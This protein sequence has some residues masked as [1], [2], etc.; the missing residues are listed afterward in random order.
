MR[1]N[2]TRMRKE[3]VVSGEP[4]QPPARRDAGQQTVGW[5]LARQEV[6]A[7]ATLEA[8]CQH[9]TAIKRDLTASVRQSLRAESARG[10]CA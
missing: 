5:G 1:E 6:G 3:E 2:A 4:H 7:S 9:S 8:S 10:C